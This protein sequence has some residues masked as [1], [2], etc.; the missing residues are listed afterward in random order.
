M[1]TAGGLGKTAY[2]RYIYE[3]MKTLTTILRSSFVIGAVLLASGCTNSLP[4]QSGVFQSTDA[5]ANFEARPDLAKPDV[6]TP[7]TYPKLAVR[8]IAQHPTQADLLV[9]GTGDDLYRTSDRGATWQSLTTKLPSA[10]KAMEVDKLA[11]QPGGGDIFYAAGVSEGYGKIFKTTDKGESF[12]DV[13]TTA[14]PKVAVTALA[15]RAD[16]SVVA[17]DRQGNVYTSPDGVTW[18][19]VFSVAN[20]ITTILLIDR[21]IYLGTYG[22][23]VFRNVDGGGFTPAVGNLSGDQLQ[24]TSLALSAGTLYAGSGQGVLSSRDGGANWQTVG[25]PFPV[26]GS[27]V[28]SVVAVPGAIYVASN[29]VV[30]RLVP[31]TGEFRSTQLK[32]AKTVFDL[33]VFPG[34]PS[35]VTAAANN[36]DPFNER[37]RTGIQRLNLIPGRQ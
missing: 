12:T 28:Q 23:G 4:E 36:E 10:T 3:L 6:K 30:Y 19:R 16:G 11:W 13:F 18:K 34:N 25:A 21:T 32:L 2:I 31:E 27:A 17:G 5:A 29:A 26:G 22:Q 8:S 37:F 24:I 15:V 14:E 35:Q 9:A 33:S 7:K 1:V 20:P